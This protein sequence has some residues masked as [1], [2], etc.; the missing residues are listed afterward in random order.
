MAL[1]D[2]VTKSK[3]KTVQTKKAKK[4]Q[5]I[6]HAGG[7][8][9][10]VDRLQRL[11]RFLVL[12]SEK[13]SY[14]ASEKKIT[15]E[16]C[17]NLMKMIKE[18]GVNVVKHIIEISQSGRA[19]KN[20]YCVFAMAMCS[21]FGDKSTKTYTNRNLHKVCRIPT[22]LYLFVDSVHILKYDP[23]TGKSRK[24]KG[25]HRAIAGYIHSKDA[26]TFAYHTC[27]YPGR[28]GEIMSQRWSMRDLLRLIRMSDKRENVIKKNVDGKIVPV[29]KQ[30][31]ILTFPSDKHKTVVRY[32]VKG[33]ENFSKKEFNSLKDDP[34]LRYIWAHE[35]AK[36]CDS[37]D[38]IAQ[39]IQNYGLSRESIPKELMGAKTYRAMLEYMPMTAMIRSLG[40]MS[41]AGLFKEFSDQQK[42][43]VN[44]LT[45][46]DLLKK[47]RIHPMNVLVALKTYSEGHGF[48][49]KLSWNVN[50]FI[51][52]ALEDA[53][54]KSF[55]YVEPTGK[56]ILYGI[57]VSASMYGNPCTGSP[58]IDA[59]SAATVMSLVGVRTEKNSMM[60]AFSHQLVDFNISSKDS[61]ENVF[62]KMR[63][64]PFGGTDCALPIEWALDN[65]I[66][67]I[68][69]FIVLTDNKTW[70]GNRHPFEAMGEYRS[71]YNENAKF[72]VQAFTATKFTIIDS[73]DDP[74]SLEV[75]GLDSAAPQII[76]D[77]IRGDI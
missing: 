14:Y 25:L 27:K 17:E 49:G 47:A 10:K 26:K 30:D 67:N 62:R 56:N 51:K 4:G 45:N 31:N 71:K 37:Q 40:P 16:N 3:R 58:M 74:N 18:D 15:V 36:N 24:G 43:V 77:F 75:V 34:D 41:A 46:E 13:G 61:I 12:G 70:A 8:V 22:D 59:A 6:N 28:A 29:T 1:A 21:V 68:D 9:F 11:T 5:V 60:K 53:F 76:A 52:D 64:I 33:I 44:K 32:A 66:S 50:S 39:L 2:H 73:K 63:S 65:Q 20:N 48:K 38:E 42:I 35:T 72:I 7:Y 19:P 57:D 55:K 54:Y 23:N 69:A